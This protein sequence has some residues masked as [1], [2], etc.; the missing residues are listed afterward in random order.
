MFRESG[1]LPR[2]ANQLLRND[3]RADSGRSSSFAW[4]RRSKTQCQRTGL[5]KWSKRGEVARLKGENLRWTA[6]V[7]NERPGIIPGVPSFVPRVTEGLSSTT[8][9]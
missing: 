8:S 3:T 5:E 2:S 9:S 4:P 7:S 1:K 6:V